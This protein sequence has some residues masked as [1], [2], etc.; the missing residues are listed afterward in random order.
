MRARTAGQRIEH[1]LA[2]G[3]TC[4][5]SGKERHYQLTLLPAGHIFGSAMAFIE[6]ASQTLLYTGDLA[7][8]TGDSHAAFSE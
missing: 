2:F 7:A 5:F 6:A 8:A 3:L 1:V 4:E